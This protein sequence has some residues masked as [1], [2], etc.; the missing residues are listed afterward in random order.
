V[1]LISGEPGIG[2]VAADGGT[3]PRT[4]KASR[5]PGLRYFCFAAPPGHARS[6]PSSAQLERAA[7]FGRR[8]YARCQARQTG[9][10]A[11]PGQRGGMT[12]IIALLSELLS[13]PSS[14]ADL[15][16]SEAAQTGEK[17]PRGIAQS[18]RSRGTAPAGADWLFEDAH[19]IDPTS[20]ELLDLCIDRV[21][22]L[23]VLFGDH[24]SARKFQ[25]P[26]GGL[27]YVMN[28]TLNRARRTAT[29]ETL[30]HKLARRC[31]AHRRD[32]R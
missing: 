4:S 28:L 29:A 20:R 7:G 30:V 26:W 16:L 3:F 27:S 1:A 21:R 22:H 10:T 2:K 8:R 24:L 25:P 15:N 14:A 6:I 12:T 18:A 31:G 11:R 19:W 13:L 23:P 5:I 17:L 32:R 9:G